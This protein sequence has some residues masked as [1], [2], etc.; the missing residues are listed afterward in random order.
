MSLPALLVRLSLLAALCIALPAAAF[1]TIWRNG[2]DYPA[3]RNSPLGTNLDGVVDYSTSYNFTDAMKQSRSWITADTSGAGVFDTDDRACLDLDENGYVRSLTPQTGNPG[4]STPSYNAVST[5]FFFGDFPGHYPSGRYIVTYEGQGDISYHFAAVRNAA[6]SAPGRDVLDVNAN[7]GGWMLRINAIAAGNHPRNIHVWMPG[8]DE[9]SGPSQLFHPDFLALIRRNKVLRFMDWMGTNNSSQQEYAGRPQL[10]DVRWS[11]GNMPLEVMVELASRS[12]AHPWFTLPHRASDDYMTRFAQDVKRLLRPDLRVYV[13][14]S[15]EVWNGQFSQG[16]YVEAQGDAAY[17]N[18][19]SGFDR[20]LNW[21]GQRSAQ[22]CDLWKSAFG[23]QAGRVVCVLGAQA[24]NA[25]TLTQAADCPLWTA[26]RPCSAHGFS[27]AA[28]APYF[29]GYLG[30]PNHAATVQTWTPTQLFAE[31]NGGGL[32]GGP[33]GGSLTEVQGWITA[34]R[35][36]AQQRSLQL[37]TYEGGQHLAGVLGNENNDAITSLFTGANRDARM[38][39]AYTQHLNFWKSAGGGLFMHFT[40][41]SGYGKFGSW[42][43]VEYLDQTGTPKHS[44]LMQFIDDNPCWW[45]DCE[46]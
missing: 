16:A 8:F 11:E 14:Y 25:Y 19:G 27:A 42:G 29:G 32:A 30:H 10:A 17:G 37:V 28:I 5:L 7:A 31:I 40:A 23:A 41:S 33:A 12:D 43:A 24:A 18:Q 6:L 2:F 22:L 26:G 15:N 39:T 4:C 46:D 3:N 45:A 13:E 35:A 9:H 20:R 21:Y 34:H 38:G 1:D 36:A 44:A